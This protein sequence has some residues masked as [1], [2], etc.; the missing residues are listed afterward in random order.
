[1]GDKDRI[2]VCSESVDFLDANMVPAPVTSVRNRTH[3]T[4]I[5]GGWIGERAIRYR[6]LVKLFPVRIADIYDGANIHGLNDIMR[7]SVDE[8][9]QHIGTIDK[10]IRTLVD[11]EVKSVQGDRVHHMNVIVRHAVDGVDSFQRYRIILNHN[12]IKRIETVAC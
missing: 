4:E 12:G 3:I 8:F 11:G 2:G 1:M 6:K 7:F 9:V 10:P 5:E